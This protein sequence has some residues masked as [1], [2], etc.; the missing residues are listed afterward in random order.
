MLYIILK[1][2]PHNSVANIKNKKASEQSKT[3]MCF[4]DQERK[5]GKQSNG[6]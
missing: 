1:T 6:E 2:K 4:N 3:K 5:V